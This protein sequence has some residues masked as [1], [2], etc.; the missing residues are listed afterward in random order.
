VYS[1]L[2]SLILK[3]QDFRDDDL[4]V[5][6]YSRESGKLTLIA[7]GA[8][9]ILSKLAGHLEPVSLSLLNAA[10]GKSIDQLTGASMVKSYSRIKADL[11][12]TA[13]AVW[14]L[15]LIDELTLENHAD[16]RIFTLA[17]RYLDFLEQK[18]EDYEVAKLAVGF[19]LLALLGL[20]PA[21][22]AELKF[23]K[24]ID[25]IVGNSIDKIYQD[26]EIKEK[27]KS[28][29]KILKEEIAI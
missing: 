2:T 17:E 12:K 9:K 20:S 3:R 29:E 26:K 14:F 25:F 28:L 27:I 22:K 11:A 7:R 8:K 5:T 6:I 23:K 19:K 15:K 24:E 4:L 21:E 1:N 16:E 18:E 13:A 10:S